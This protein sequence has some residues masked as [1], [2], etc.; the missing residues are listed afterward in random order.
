MWEFLF[1][2]ISLVDL[3]AY[4]SIEQKK[5]VLNQF[6]YW[7]NLVLTLNIFGVNSFIIK[8]KKIQQ[9]NHNGQKLIGGND[10][11]HCLSFWG[12]KYWVCSSSNC[13][14]EKISFKH[15]TFEVPSTLE[16]I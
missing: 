6:P 10:V 5:V 7:L 1:Y 12:Y 16:V 8:M 15:I 2:E 4:G 11:L 9:T 3:K 13:L 14:L